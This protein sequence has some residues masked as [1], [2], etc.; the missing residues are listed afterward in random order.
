MVKKISQ[1]ILVMILLFLETLIQAA[2]TENVSETGHAL[3]G[4]DPVSYHGGAAKKGNPKYFLNH[5]GVKYVFTSRKNIELFQKQP[6]KFKPAFGGWC[7]WAMLEGKKVDVDPEKFKIINGKTY[8]YYTS[9]FVDTLEK[10]N[11][12]AQTESEEV[13]TKKANINWQKLMSDR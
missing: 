6:N 1:A 4:Y 10:W 13:L 3:H 8:L 11:E 7:A 5:D 12:L 2:N 9:F